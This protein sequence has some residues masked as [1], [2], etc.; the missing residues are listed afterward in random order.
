MSKKIAIT[1]LE[2]MRMTFKSILFI[3]A[4][5][6][7]NEMLLDPHL[8]IEPY[9]VEYPVLSEDGKYQGKLTFNIRKRKLLPIKNIDAEIYIEYGKER[10]FLVNWY[11]EKLSPAIQKNMPWWQNKTIATLLF[12]ARKEEKAGVEDMPLIRDES[13]KFN[14]IVN[15]HYRTWMKIRDIEVFER[16]KYIPNAPTGKKQF[17]R[18]E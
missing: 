8:T 5:I 17:A 10:P 1:L 16:Y 18:I 6:Y 14:V 12:Q 2:V 13:N 7:A 11:P 15:I 4:F 9:R 3:V